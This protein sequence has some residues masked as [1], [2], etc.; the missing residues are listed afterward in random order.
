M[1]VVERA[2]PTPSED[3][4]TKLEKELSHTRLALEKYQTEC[5]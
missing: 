2:R 4:L 3:E 1:L 5:R